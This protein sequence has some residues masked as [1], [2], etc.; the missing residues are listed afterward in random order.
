[1]DDSWDDI[2]TALAVA[3]EGTV[4]GA[5]QQLDLH[6]AT[7]IRHVDA[8]EARLGTRLFTRG[9]RGYA[10]TDA[11]RTLLDLG[12]Q[13]EQTLAQ[14]AARIIAGGGG[15][16]GPL[17]ITALPGLTDLVLP[18]RARLM[19][20][21][22]GLRV[23]YRTDSR[24]YRLEAGE[25]HIAIRAGAKPSDADYV[26]QPFHLLRAALYPAPS[27][28]AAHGG[29]DDPARHRFILPAE[30][31]Q[32]APIMRWLS[33]RITDDNHALVSNDPV[34]RRAAVLSGL[35]I[36]MLTPDEAGGMVEMLALPDWHSPLWL[37]T[38]VDLHRSAK[39]QTALAA[40]KDG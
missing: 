18:P 2:R 5:A 3:R 15:I 24:L 21:H 23:A 17:V 30:E 10:M 12:G 16:D 22:P 36:G 8:I 25:A 20:A 40:L 31:E 38:H 37:V 34:L 33:Q 26:V 14:M 1:M 6:H 7:V 39:V 35:G 27:Y 11:G 13:A 19:R 28:V 4:S 32:G 9:P 29:L